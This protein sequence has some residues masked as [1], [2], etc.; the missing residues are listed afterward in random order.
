VG[1]I[2]IISGE[3]RGRR[4]KVPSGS[5]VRPTSDR[6]REALFSIL[7]ERIPGARVLDAYSGSGA[8]GFEALSRG[9]HE[10][11]FVES[12]REVLAVLRENAATLGILDRCTI[13]PIE[14]GAFLAGGPPGKPFDVVLADPPYAAGEAARFLPV[15]S[16]SEWM[17]REGL[18]VLERDRRDPPMEVAGHGVVLARTAR[19]GSTGL[20]IYSR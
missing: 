8:L 20:D 16:T 6:V 12:A 19:Y 4:I 13:F 3:F 10:V 11:V 1:R 17:S 7:G 14:V 5:A 18:I 9:A 15:V 2:R